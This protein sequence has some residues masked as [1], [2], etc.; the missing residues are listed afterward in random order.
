MTGNLQPLDQKFPIV[1]PDG[2]PTL[3]FI[4]WAQQKQIDISEGITA[5]QALQ[6]IEQYLADHTLQEGSGISISPSGNLSDAPTIA[7][8]VQAILDQITNVQGSVLFRGAAGWEA[9]APGASGRFLRT[10][11]AGADPSWATAGG[12]GGSVTFW[13]WG[14]VMLPTP[15]NAIGSTNATL[16]AGSINAAI[17]NANRGNWWWW[18]TGQSLRN[19]TF[20][21]SSDQIISGI[22]GYQDSNSSNGIWQPQYSDDGVNFTNIGASNTWGGA[23]QFTW[24][25]ANSDPHRYWRLSQISGTT[26][27]S[28]W[29]QGFMFRWGAA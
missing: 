20:N 25:F 21:F 9:L 17:Q 26:S 14:F 6:I 18:N 24:V 11:G 12:G 22:L 29:Q 5:E 16:G 10:N 7:A 15:F 27:N 2:R 3:Y 23:T 28:A 1:T 8:E 4:K 19:V 13:G